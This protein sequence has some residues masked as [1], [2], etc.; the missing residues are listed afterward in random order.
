MEAEKSSIFIPFIVLV[1]LIVC[2]NA[3]VRFL[4]NKNFSVAIQ[5]Q[6]TVNTANCESVECDEVYEYLFA[7]SPGETI[8]VSEKL[9]P[10]KG[11]LHCLRSGECT[12]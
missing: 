4:V 1:F 7:C 5:Q 2:I 10:A 11:F 9:V 3:T 12:F 6:C 8:G